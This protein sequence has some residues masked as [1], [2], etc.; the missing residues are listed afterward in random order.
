M[1]NGIRHNAAPLKPAT[2]YSSFKPVR[3]RMQ[4]H[5]VWYPMIY[6]N[7]YIKT[8]IKQYILRSTGI[9]TQQRN[10]IQILPE[11][12]CPKADIYVRKYTPAQ[13]LNSYSAKNWEAVG[14]WTTEYKL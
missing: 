14:F 11:L 13:L 10:G 9:P 8:L 3:V 6:Y 12:L 4:R 1:I 2:E 7:F 5:Y